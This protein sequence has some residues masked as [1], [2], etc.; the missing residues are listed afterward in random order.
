MKKFLAMMAA[1]FACQTG[2]AGNW[3]VGAGL[4]LAHANDASKNIAADNSTLAQYG[5]SDITSYDDHSG[6]LSFLGGYRFNPHIAAELSY[7]YLGSYDMHGFTAPGRT[8]PSGRERNHADAFSLAAVLTAP[9]NDSISLYG[10]LGPTLAMNEERTCVSDIRW[11]DSSSDAKIGSIVGAGASFTFPRLIGELRLE[12]DQFSHVG[13]TH[14]EF[15]AGRFSLLQ[16]Q[17]VYSFSE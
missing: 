11:C 3:Y 14:N 7:N 15:T 9:L 13:D 12:I 1:L 6:A 4:G 2:Y 10:K 16:I 17:Y 8:P 5:I